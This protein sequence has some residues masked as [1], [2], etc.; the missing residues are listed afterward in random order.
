MFDYLAIATGA[1]QSPPAKLAAVEKSEGC[2]ELRILQDK[3]ENANKIAVVG[4][5][6][7]G[8][9]IAGDVKSF[10]A[11]K[12]VTIIH[13]RERLLS[14]SGRKLHEYVLEK[15]EKLGV[16]VVLG[17]RPGLLSEI[18]WEGAEIIFKDWGEEVFNL[19]VCGVCYFLW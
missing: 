5:G 18:G 4:A 1:S 3:I 13:S 15:F 2:E 16:D 8:V 12:K 7:V 17:E 9:Q 14:N 6:A 19:A 11:E 10:Y